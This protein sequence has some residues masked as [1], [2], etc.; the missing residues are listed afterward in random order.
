MSV[1][2]PSLVVDAIRAEY[3]HPDHTL[4]N[5]GAG[6]ALGVGVGCRG[7]MAGCV[8]GRYPAHKPLAKREET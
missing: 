7:G 8:S 6:G 3:P 4:K 5:G 2:Y 1:I